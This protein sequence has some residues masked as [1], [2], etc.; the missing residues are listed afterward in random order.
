[1][2]KEIK[3]M[4]VAAA[5]SAV[6]APVLADDDEKGEDTRPYV[7]INQEDVVNCVDWICSLF[8]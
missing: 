3:W 1:M 6:A 5:V 7:S 4:L 8:K 2:M